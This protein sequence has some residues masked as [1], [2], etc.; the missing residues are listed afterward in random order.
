MSEWMFQSEFRTFIEA[1]L[2][3]VAILPPV[4]LRG[5]FE[6]GLEQIGRELAP[7]A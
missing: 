7:V 5:Q 3:N 6:V 4:D 1:E 2:L